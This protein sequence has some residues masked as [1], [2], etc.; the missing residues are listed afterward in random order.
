[1]S[2]WGQGVLFGIFL[3]LVFSLPLGLGTYILLFEWEPRKQRDWFQLAGE[4]PYNTAGDYDPE[5]LS[6]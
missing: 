5:E 6:N 1:M 3:G 2:E 4:D